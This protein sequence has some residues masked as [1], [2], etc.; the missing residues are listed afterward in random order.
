MRPTAAEGEV[1]PAASR[2]WLEVCR[3]GHANPE[4]LAPAVGMDLQDCGRLLEHMC[5]RRLL[6]R[7]GTAYHPLFDTFAAAERL[8]EALPRSDFDG[9]PTPADT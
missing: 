6:C 3:A 1:D 4:D 2:V 7:D 8:G 9:E 5:D